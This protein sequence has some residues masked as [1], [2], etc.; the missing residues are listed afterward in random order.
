MTEPSP[1]EGRARLALVVLAVLAI[2]LP[3]V[4][5][6]LCRDQGIYAY[7]GWRLLEGDLPYRDVYAFKPP[8]TVFMHALSQVVF[9]H[10]QA[11]IRWLDLTLLMAS[12]VGLSVLL[13]R[14]TRSA[15]AGAVAGVMLPWLHIGAGI[16]DSAQTDPWFT[17]FTV[18]ALLLVTGDTLDDRRSFA[19]GL[20]LS[21]AFWLKYTGLAM[22]LPLVLAV[23]MRDVPGRDRLRAIGLG[24]AGFVAGLAVVVAWMAATGILDDFIEAQQLVASYTS[25]ESHKRG[26]WDGIQHAWDKQR[27]RLLPAW[28]GI[29]AVGVPAM[30]WTAWRDPEAR[31]GV[32]VTLGW[33][34]AAVASIAAQ[35]RWFGYHVM[36]FSPVVAMGGAW[37]AAV[38]AP[39]LPRALMWVAAVG[40]AAGLAVEMGSDK[41]TWPAAMA[42]FEDREAFLDTRRYRQFTGWR[43]YGNMASRI[44][45]LTEP[46]EPVY[47]YSYDPAVAY[48]AD[49]RMVGRFLYTF[50]YINGFT[51]TSAAHAELMASLKAEPPAVFAVG[52]KDRVTFVTGNRYD[53]A[54]NFNRDK[55]LRPWVEEH[56]TRLDDVHRWKV[57]LRND[58]VDRVAR[59]E[60]HPSDR[61]PPEPKAPDTDGDAP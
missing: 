19:G 32:L 42:S 18:G 51:D 58:L 17:P 53:S 8:G 24:V 54:G 5:W 47:V 1:A 55:V 61:P 12:S 38:L 33:G 15:A 21:G 23:A 25:V 2:A 7:T 22:A 31:P 28:A 49:R 20:L 44:A 40:L 52:Y 26:L 56:Y 43:R 35:R 36:A 11:A 3:M 59:E 13:T 60:I 37:I 27:T 14:W 50:P 34:V 10:T 6:P 39:W 41:E 48:V 45:E 30:V 9:G 4:V 57:Y 16:W 29:L 46:D